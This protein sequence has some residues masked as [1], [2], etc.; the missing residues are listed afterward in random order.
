MEN[1]WQ[2]VRIHATALSKINLQNLVA[3]K[4]LQEAETRGM[5]GN[6]MGLH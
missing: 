4:S 3:G 2:P 6:T 1:Q 5:R